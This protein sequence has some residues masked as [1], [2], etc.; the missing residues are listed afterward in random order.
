M[1]RPKRR[2]DEDNG[3]PEGT[4]SE[5]G[6]PSGSDIGPEIGDSPET[7]GTETGG[8]E[9]G[10]TETGGTETGGTE[11]GGTETGRAEKPRK[12]KSARYKT[13]GGQTEKAIPAH[14]K[15][16]AVQVQG[17]HLIAA[18]L[19]GFSELVI[20]EDESRAVAGAIDAIAREY[21]IKISS[22]YGAIL[23]AGITLTLVYAPRVA[24]IAMAV[25]ARKAQEA[26]S[27]KEAEMAVVSREDRPLVPPA[28]PEPGSSGGTLGFMSHDPGL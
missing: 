10:G 12:P 27:K 5:S 14:L 15:A 18:Q 3:S 21:K 17:F 6:R 9:T 24:S 7:G 8:T 13:G 26:Q 4:E 2:T 1:A 28:N 25:K 23:N 16:L 22:K 20:S 19:T 11:T